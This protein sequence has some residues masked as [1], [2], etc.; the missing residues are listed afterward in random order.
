MGRVSPWQ[1]T[2]FR[3]Y[4]LHLVLTHLLQ[5]WKHVSTRTMRFVSWNQTKFRT[6]FRVALEKCG[7]PKWDYKPY[8]LRRGGATDL[9][10][11]EVILKYR[12]LD[13]GHPNALQWCT[14]TRLCFSFNSLTSF[15]NIHFC[16]DPEAKSFYAPLAGNICQKNGDVEERRLPPFHE[17]FLFPE[18]ALWRP[19][20]WLCIA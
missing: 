11:S 20:K 19:Q 6:F 2:L 8:S 10:I 9:W 3:A 5:K 1:E 17:V 16:S 4:R 15:N 18:I 12:A 14:Y 13:A 7:L